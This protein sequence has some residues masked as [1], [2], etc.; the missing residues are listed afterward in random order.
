[1]G[2]YGGGGGGPKTDKTPASKSAVN[3]SV[4]GPP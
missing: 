4:P 1:M 2:S 3:P